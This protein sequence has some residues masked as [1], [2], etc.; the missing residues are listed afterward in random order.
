MGAAGG[1]PKDCAD[2]DEKCPFW[3]TIGGCAGNPDYMKPNCPLSCGLCSSST[4]APTRG[5]APGPVPTPTPAPGACADKDEKCLLEA[6]RRVHRQPR[7]HETELPLV[8]RIR[9]KVRAWV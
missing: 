6:N 3:K 1:A 5:P 9:T 7:L 2:K 8:L 4:P